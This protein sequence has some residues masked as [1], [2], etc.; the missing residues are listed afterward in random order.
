MIQLAIRMLMLDVTE[1][2]ARAERVLREARAMYTYKC[3]GPW[4]TNDD[5]TSFQRK[6]RWTVARV[7]ITKSTKKRT[8]RWMYFWVLC[9]ETVGI[10]IRYRIDEE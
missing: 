6:A 4:I 2:V 9:L 5:R 8:L 1:Y 3:S 7:Y 10:A